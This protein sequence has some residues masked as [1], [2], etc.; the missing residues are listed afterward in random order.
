MIRPDPDF[1]KKLN[2][3]HPFLIGDFRV[4]IKNRFVLVR[5][6]VRDPEHSFS[7]EEAEAWLSTHSA[8]RALSERRRSP[9][10]SP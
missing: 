5:S 1:P 6:D 4:L 10:R 3:D 2:G 7:L 8:S 9:Q